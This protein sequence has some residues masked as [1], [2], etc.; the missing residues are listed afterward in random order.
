MLF[1]MGFQWSGAMKNGSMTYFCKWVMDNTFFGT[2][3]A[4]G[5]SQSLLSIMGAVPMAVAAVAI[6]PLCNKFGKRIVCMV[7]M[8][9]GSVGGVIAIMGNGQIDQ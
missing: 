4:W 5:A 7:G 9:L 1:Y 2:A 6:V 8:L 3:D